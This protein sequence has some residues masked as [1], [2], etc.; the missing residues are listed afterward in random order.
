[1][2]QKC[3]GLPMITQLAT[4]QTAATYAAGSRKAISVPSALADRALGCIRGSARDAGRA[5]ATQ[6]PR[7]NSAAAS[8][9][10]TAS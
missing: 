8:T 4:I 3:S 10:T 1:M 6:Q 5:R 2:R 9:G 7:M